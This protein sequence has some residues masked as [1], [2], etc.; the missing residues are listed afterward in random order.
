MRPVNRTRGL[1]PLLRALAAAAL[2]VAML[3][4]GAAMATA[5]GDAA[6]RPVRARHPG[7][8][9]SSRPVQSSPVRAGRPAGPP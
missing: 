2:V 9:P 3:A 5:G 7:A 8:R 6:I 1:A 4:A